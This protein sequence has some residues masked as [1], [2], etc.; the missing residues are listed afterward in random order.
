M[1]FENV[2]YTPDKVECIFYRILNLFFSF[3]YNYYVSYAKYWNMCKLFF[4]LNG[5][6]QRTVVQIHIHFVSNTG[7]DNF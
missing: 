3:Y 7:I 4:G 2:R 6:C 1:M 5:F